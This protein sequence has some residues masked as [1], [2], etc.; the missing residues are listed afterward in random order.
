[1]HKSAIIQRFFLVVFMLLSACG[2]NSGGGNSP[3][4][5]V[6]EISNNTVSYDETIHINNCGGKAD[7]EQTASR[8]F[9]TNIEGGI[10]IGVQ[11]IVEGSISAKYSQYRNISKSMRLLAPPGTNMEFI[12]RWSEDVHAGNVTA[13]GSNGTYEVRV[14]IGVE[15]VSS[16]DLGC[17]GI[18]PSSNNDVNPAPTQ[19]PVLLP[20]SLPPSLCPDFVSRSVVQSWTIGATDVAIVDAKVAN[21]NNYRTYPRGNFV[22]GDKIPAGVVVATSFDGAGRS[23]NEFPVQ[24]LVHRG[25]YGLFESL[26]EYIAPYEGACISI[27]P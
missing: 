4:I 7:S 5:R 16:Q 19:P 20:T 10:E 21:F 9:A 24:P 27:V 12:L 14:P 1:M 3:D 15:Q 25:N 13:N 22:K 17:G 23:W 26:A 8:S 18:P 2:N 6:D 11:Q